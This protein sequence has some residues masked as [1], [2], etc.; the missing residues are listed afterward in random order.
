MRLAGVNRELLGITAPAFPYGSTEYTFKFWVAF[1]KSRLLCK[2]VGKSYTYI[3]IQSTCTSYFVH[4]TSFR[5]Q[6]IL[7]RIGIY[8]PRLHSH[9]YLMASLPESMD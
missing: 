8:G 3:M 7:V 5:L 2:S 9:P 6:S 4:H 1:L